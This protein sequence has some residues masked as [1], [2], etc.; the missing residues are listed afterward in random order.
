[1]ENKWI[2]LLNIRGIND[3]GADRTVSTLHT[4]IGT[5]NKIIYPTGGHAI[6]NYE[7][8]KS[9]YVNPEQTSTVTNFIVYGS[10]LVQGGTVPI[11]SP[12]SECTGPACIENT[13]PHGG[14][15]VSHTTFQIED[16]GN[17]LTCTNTYPHPNPYLLGMDF[18]QDPLE[19]FIYG[20]LGTYISTDAVD[21][22]AQFCEVE[23][24]LESECISQ[25][26]SQ[27]FDDAGESL[28]ID[29]VRVTAYRN[30]VT[31][32]DSKVISDKEI[33]AVYN[34]R[35]QVSTLEKTNEVIIIKYTD[36]TSERIFNIR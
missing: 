34:E 30:T 25:V 14:P 28:F 7:S 16:E 15:K 32:I 20:S 6:F 19:Y 22:A 27:I 11:G 3:D 26:H 12:E 5:L 17:Y 23:F 31:A 21:V 18:V 36:G 1:M 13:G 24:S 4:K 35:G 8:H 33:L 29:D 2:V 10:N 9:S